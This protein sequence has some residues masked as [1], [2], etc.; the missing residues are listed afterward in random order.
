MRTSPNRPSHSHLASST[1]SSVHQSALYTPPMSSSNLSGPIYSRSSHQ[2]SSVSPSLSSPITIDDA[3]SGCTVAWGTLTIATAWAGNF[4]GLV[5]LR[6][7]LGVFEGRSALSLVI[8]LTS[9][10]SLFPAVVIICSQ[11]YRRSEMGTRMRS[12]QSSMRQ[13]AA[14]LTATSS[15]ALRLAELL[16]VSLHTASFRSMQ[17]D[18]SDGNGCTSSKASS[19]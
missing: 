15:P 12:V 1:T 5:A 3:V 14:D 19:H 18:W 11:T 17:V 6:V 8:L 9:Q 10:A 13:P 4:H 7:L 16:V 2:R